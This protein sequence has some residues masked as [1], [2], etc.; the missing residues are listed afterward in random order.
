MS[1][2]QRLLTRYSNLSSR[3]RYLVLFCSIFIL[4]IMLWFLLARPIY[5]YY[6]SSKASYTES[7]DLLLWMNQN[8]SQLSKLSTAPHSDPETSSKPTDLF[9]F[10]TSAAEASSIEIDRIEPLSNDRLRSVYQSVDFPAFYQFIQ[11]IE[12]NGLIVESLT[13]EA[14]DAP[15]YVKATLILRG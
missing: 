7:N 3:E 11:S 2:I 12:H 13:V 8:K 6:H 9:Q 14:L 4:A 5:G 10:L 1:S 15:G